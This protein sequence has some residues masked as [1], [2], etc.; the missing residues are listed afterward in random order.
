MNPTSQAYAFILLF[1]LQAYGMDRVKEETAT[2][3]KNVPTHFAITHETRSYDLGYGLTSLSG[4]TVAIIKLDQEMAPLLTIM[5]DKT[6][7]EEQKEDAF[8]KYKAFYKTRLQKLRAQ[9]VA[10]KIHSDRPRAQHR[11]EVLLATT[12]CTITDYTKIYAVLMTI[13]KRTELINYQIELGTL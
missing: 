8:A 9:T 5:Y 4:P 1:S 13:S 10:A 6:S 11:A 7:T 3:V 2:T 12:L